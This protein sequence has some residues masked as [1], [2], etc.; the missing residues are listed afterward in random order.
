ML[1]V[2]C[3]KKEVG[4]TMR[5]IV[6]TEDQARVLRE[7]GDTVE[8]RD[9]QGRT[10]AHLTPLSPAD[11]EAIERSKQARAAGGSRVQSGGRS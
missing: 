3:V 10:V 8:V 4:I 9:E 2:Q 6:L 1:L 11:I 7:A 5:H